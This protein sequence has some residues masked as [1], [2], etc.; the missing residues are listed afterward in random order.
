MASRGGGSRPT[1]TD[2]S[3][4]LLIEKFNFFL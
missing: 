2:G 1:G 3:F 4:F